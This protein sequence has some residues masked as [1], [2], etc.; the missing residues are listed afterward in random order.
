MAGRPASHDWKRFGPVVSFAQRCVRAVKRRLYGPRLQSE[1]QGPLIRLGSEYGGWTFVDRPSLWK[2]SVISGGL[3]EDASFDVELASRFGCRVVMVDPTPRAVRHF[4][5]IESRIGLRSSVPYTRHGRQ[6][7]LSYDM[8]SIVA[9]QLTLVEEA[10]A[11]RS[12]PIK[13]YAPPDDDSVSYSIVNFQQGYATDT[14]FIEVEAVD[15]LT[16][17]Q[18]Q[19]IQQ[20]ALMKLDIEGAEIQVIPD[21]LCSGMLPEQLLVEFDELNWPSRASTA[22]FRT[23]H[24]QILSAGYRVSYF[25]RRSCVSYVQ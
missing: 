19:G 14:P 9:G 1:W 10:L 23:V 15:V 25:N 4:A 8:R 13:F 2:G 22:K 12:G 11:D 24:E 6:N 3:G 21:L 16:L 20:L 5:E 7:A 17:L 18:D